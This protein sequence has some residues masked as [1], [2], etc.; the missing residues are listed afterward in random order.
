MFLL[1]ISDAWGACLNGSGIDCCCDFKKCFLD[2]GTKSYTIV[3]FTNTI[4]MVKKNLNI[5]FSFTCE[6]Y[7]F[8][9]LIKS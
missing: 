3:L 4:A 7:Y 5:L 1:A 9:L 8:L 6:N 2:S